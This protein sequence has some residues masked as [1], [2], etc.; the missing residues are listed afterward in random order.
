MPESECPN[1][2]STFARA[3]NDVN[4][5]KAGSYPTTFGVG[6][7]DESGANM[8]SRPAGGRRPRRAC[9][10][11][12][13]LAFLCVGTPADPSSGGWS[14]HTAPWLQ[15][16]PSSRS[17]MQVGVPSRRQPRK[18][19]PPNVGFFLGLD[20]IPKEVTMKLGGEAGGLCS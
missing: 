9:E 12:F 6:P 5:S 17:V 4:R 2:T 7:L 18:T 13:H 10:V 1:S 14:Q 8:R 19:G 16:S 15:R 3:E 11:G 20:V